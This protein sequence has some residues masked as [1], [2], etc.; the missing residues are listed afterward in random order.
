MALLWT[1]QIRQSIETCFLSMKDGPHL[2]EYTACATDLHRPLF[3]TCVTNEPS[4]TVVDVL[5]CAT[6]LVD[7]LALLWALPIANLLYRS[8]TLPHHLLH[9]LLLESYL[10]LLL[11]VLLAG[12]LLR[13]L[14]VGDVGVVA[15][16][17][18]LVGAFQDRVFG[19]SLHT[20]FFH[21]AQPSIRKPGGG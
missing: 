17:H 2:F 12:L 18:V 4:L 16:L 19:K 5:R 13:G 6:R 10:A 15:L 1:L 21:N 14:E 11:K 3:T 8:I 20:F 7:G 9:R